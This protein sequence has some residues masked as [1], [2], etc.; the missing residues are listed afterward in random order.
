MSVHLILAAENTDHGTAVHC[1]PAH[2]HQIR[3]RLWVQRMALQFAVAGYE[4]GGV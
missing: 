1:I 4:L 2:I 3:V